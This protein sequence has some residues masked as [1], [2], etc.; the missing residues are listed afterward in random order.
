MTTETQY[1]RDERVSEFDSNISD[2]E[3]NVAEVQLTVANAARVT[4]PQGQRVVV[5]PVTPGETVELPTASP[6]GLLAELGPQGNLAI[7]VDG[8]TIILQG[9]AAANEESPIH[10]VTDDGDEVDVAFVL[11]ETDP[12]LDIQ[13]AA[14]PAAGSPGGGA[15]GGSGIFVPLPAG[16]LL[17]GF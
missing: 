17:G 1:S 15:D 12:S 6:D 7:V 11:S 14:G 8:R 9:Y 10:V 16:P 3:L 13:T 4:L 5:V 2:S